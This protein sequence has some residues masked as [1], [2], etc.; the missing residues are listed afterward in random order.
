M[1]AKHQLAKVVMDAVVAGS[2]LPSGDQSTL[3]REMAL[4]IERREELSKQLDTMRAR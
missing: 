3:A 4:A 2:R 1:N